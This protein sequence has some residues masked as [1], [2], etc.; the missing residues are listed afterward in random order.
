MQ[1]VESNTLDLNNVSNLGVV[2]GAFVSINQNVNVSGTSALTSTNF[3]G[4]ATI[5]RLGA[6]TLGNNLNNPINRSDCV[7]MPAP[8]FS[9]QDP[10]RASGM[11][12][13]EID[14]NA[15]FAQA[16]GLTGIASGS[17]VTVT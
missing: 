4:N 5:T 13:I 14:G 9:Q 6:I 12:V 16:A 7:L 15:A 8:T 1:V 3:N 17:Q 11:G 10:L 2:S